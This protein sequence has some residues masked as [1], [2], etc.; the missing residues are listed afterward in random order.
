VLRKEKKKEEEIA[1]KA[2][3]LRKIQKKE[4][5]TGGTIANNMT[6]LIQRLN[7]SREL[8]DARLETPMSRALPSPL[9]SESS[10]ESDQNIKIAIDSMITTIEDK[11]VSG[12]TI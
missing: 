4:R 12:N 2:I 10:N 3:E 8:I 11:D 7:A 6:K 1:M 5:I 9:S